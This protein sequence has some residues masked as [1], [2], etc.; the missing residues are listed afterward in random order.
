MAEKQ[1]WQGFGTII[2]GKFEPFQKISERLANEK[3]NC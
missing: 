3:K 2:S 1:D